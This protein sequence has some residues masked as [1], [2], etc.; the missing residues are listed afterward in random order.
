VREAKA[1]QLR[2]SDKETKSPTTRVMPGSEQGDGQHPNIVRYRS[3]YS[4]LCALPRTTSI[5]SDKN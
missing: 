3:G 5:K 2:E 1:Q 4:Q